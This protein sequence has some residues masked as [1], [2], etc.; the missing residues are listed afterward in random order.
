MLSITLFQAT[1]LHRLALFSA[2]GHIC[3]VSVHV[4]R[5][6]RVQPQGRHCRECGRGSVRAVPGSFDEWTGSGTRVLHHSCF[7][8]KCMKMFFPSLSLFVT[9]PLHSSN[10]MKRQSKRPEPSVWVGPDPSLMPSGAALVILTIVTTSYNA[11]FGLDLFIYITC[12]FSL[13]IHLITGQS[14]LGLLFK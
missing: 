7:L 12:L 1:P 8:C 10:S 9:A 11:S 14:H 13:N 3:C 6:H 4:S 2:S 5:A